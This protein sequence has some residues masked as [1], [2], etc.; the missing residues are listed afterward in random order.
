[1]LEREMSGARMD[2]RL[3]GEELKEVDCFKYL[4][5]TVTVDRRVKTG[6]M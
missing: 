3:N 4:G 6:E 2:V 5:S 1:M